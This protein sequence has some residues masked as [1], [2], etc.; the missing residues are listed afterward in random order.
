MKPNL[1]SHF[2]FTLI[3]VVLVLAVLAGGLI[4]KSA[5]AA[6][7]DLFASINGSR[8]ICQNG[9]GS[10]FQ[11]TPD[12][13]QST[14]VP[15]LNAPQ[16]LDHPRSL[17]FDNAGNLFVTTTTCDGNTGTFQGT[18]FKITP[19]GVTSTFA[20]ISGNFFIGGL[21]VD[22]AGNVFVGAGNQDPN[23]PST[24]IFK[25][26]PQGT[27]STFGTFNNSGPGLA[28][29]SA[30]NLFAADNADQTIY[31]FTPGGVQSVF[32]GPAAFVSGEGP[33]GLAFD[34]FGNLFVSTEIITGDENGN[35]AILEF[36][37]NFAPNGMPT[38]FATGLNTPKGLAFD[39]AGN[40][41]VAEIPLHPPGSCPCGD[42]LEFTPGGG[43]T[44]ISPPFASGIGGTDG[45][46][47]PEF[48]A[49]MPGAV[50]PTPVGSN[51]M[52]NSGT[53]GSAVIALTF[54]QVTVG[55][56]TTVMPIDPSSA[57]TLPSGYQLTGGN[58]AFE[59]TTTAT[60]TT[61]PP[62]IIAFQVP[63][64]DAATFSQLRV[65]H[66]EGGTLVDRTATNP[67]PNPTTQT[68]YASVSSLSPFV[69]AKDTVTFD[70]LIA[71]TRRSVTNSKVMY[72]LVAALTIA[73][74]ADA[75]G[76]PKIEDLALKVYIKLVSLVSGK[77][78]TPQNAAILIS[79]ARTL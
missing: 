20:T 39:G 54:P 67:A 71:L 12:G 3:A 40:L 55:G 58:L 60:Y 11:Y 28:F 66:T 7:G 36:A 16:G 65:L 78:I 26:T 35:D 73:K 27:V 34:R 5:Y 6:P 4:P 62:I 37:P 49:F 76:F 79:E 9:T 21:V 23:V 19:G 70:S 42:I 53:V 61:P 22:S 38:T 30:G 15:N 46:V 32:A 8:G 45:N 69:I 72:D 64:V 48:L 57:G 59:I 10:I 24:T 52:V 13:T 63:S 41:F 25:V 17:A 2:K 77:F 47:G 33:V 44:A 31:K 29:D 75:R 50:T 1:P 18:I 43:G 51:V 68:I 74:N 14:F 56:T